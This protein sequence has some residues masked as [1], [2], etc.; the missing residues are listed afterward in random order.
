M[1]IRRVWLILALAL[2]FPAAAWCDYS[3]AIPKMELAITPQK[4]ASVLLE[5]TIVFACQPGADPKDVV[6]VG[7]PDRHYDLSN[8][9]AALNGKPLT[10]IRKSTV[11][12][13][14]VEV[15]FPDPIQPGAKGTFTFSCTMPDR[16][17]QDT[18]DKTMASLRMTP[19][20][21]NPKYVVGNTD[22]SIVVYLPLSVK[23]TD[24]RTQLNQSFTAK[25]IVK[26]HTFAAWY[27]KGT[28]MD[29]KHE[30][31]I[32]FPRAWMD[33]VV[34]QTAWD[35]A[36]KWWTE[37][38]GAR[39]AW[40]LL[41]FVLLGIWFFRM[42]RGTGC[43]LYVIILVLLGI[44]WANSPALELLGLPVLIAVW[45]LT[46]RWQ[47]AKKRDYLPAIASVKG[48]GIKRGLTVPEAA[49]VLE[50]PLNKVLALVLF[51][52][53]T[54][55]LLLQKQA[56]PLL[57]VPAPGY[58]GPPAERR[59]TAAA[60][61]NVIR[62]YEQEFLDALAAAPEKNVPDV[63]FKAAMKELVSG[64]AQGLAGFDLDATREYYQ[65]IVS[66]AWADAKALGDVDQRTSFVDNN[67]LWL[68][69][70]PNYNDNFGMW[71]HGGYYYSAPWTRGAPL[72]LGGGGVPAP[73][74]GNTTSLG[75]VAGS[76]AGWA[77]NV[78]GKLAGTVDP[79]NLGLP[80]G[81]IDL[82]GLDKV[83]GEV[84]SS[85]ASG[86][87]GGGGGGG[88]CACAGCACA[89]ACAGGG[90]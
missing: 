9:K 44:F 38:D 50:V 27:L 2:L 15:H 52:M 19:T 24:L 30:I 83:S 18:T 85:M 21:F 84:L 67:L 37:S 66:K 79:A 74:P 87:G 42:T 16:V 29:D 81:S 88:G 59:K 77:E 64:T 46:G 82:S 61:G 14:A 34:V 1:N 73:A 51:G 89:C 56:D 45:V 48:G 53:L 3:Y 5:Y 23:P 13:S 55:K 62:G 36:W 72:D 78:S 17:Y 28:R 63:D 90:R 71:G 20:Y 33:H 75:D 43:T 41:L 8:M 39:L 57:V 7:L 60:Q 54:K 10:D 47:G 25:G 4:D 65:T 11:L 40:G 49:V 6:D 35:L 86:S 68:M 22:L 76:F 58:E 32:S 80:S 26:N 12:D 31:G 69:M 70:A